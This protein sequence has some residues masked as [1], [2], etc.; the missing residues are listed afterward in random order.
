[1]KL[2]TLDFQQGKGL[3][4][5]SVTSLSVEEIMMMCCSVL[6]VVI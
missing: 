2:P 5:E 4:G 6:R 1:M 3:L